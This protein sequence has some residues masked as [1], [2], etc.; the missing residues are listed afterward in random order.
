[1]VEGA[2][3]LLHE[4]CQVRGHG[5]HYLGPVLSLPGHL[6]HGEADVEGLPQI[7]IVSPLQKFRFAMSPKVQMSFILQ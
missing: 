4:G 1:M 7:R 2:E 3:P 5:G 6:L